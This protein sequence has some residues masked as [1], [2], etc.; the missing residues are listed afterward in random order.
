MIIEIILDQ[1]TYLN[2]FN[3]IRLLTKQAQTIRYRSLISDQSV[4]NH[5]NSVNEV[6]HCLNGSVVTYRTIELSDEQSSL[7]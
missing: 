7:S 3:K 6:N 1:W 4:V 5:L 2:L